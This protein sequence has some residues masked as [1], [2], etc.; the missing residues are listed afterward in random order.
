M[1]LLNGVVG[2]VFSNTPT[3]WNLFWQRI[4]QNMMPL[5]STCERQDGGFFFLE[6]VKYRNTQGLFT[7]NDER[8]TVM[9]TVRFLL[10]NT[11][12]WARLHQAWASMQRWR[13]RH[14]SHWNQWK[15]IVASEWGCNLIA[16]DSIDFNES[17]VASID[18]A[19][20]PTLG[21]NGPKKVVFQ[22]N[23]TKVDLTEG[24]EYE[25]IFFRPTNKFQAQVFLLN[26]KSHRQK[27][28]WSQKGSGNQSDLN[29]I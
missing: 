7:H 5:S 28:H 23:I 15:Q 8:V 9:A 29:G 2:A 24:G 21:V 22:L 27:R 14:N 12:V 18:P 4:I 3:S 25:D 1:R 6:I 26:S 20:T 19:L 17:Y 16:S 10:L 13:L 11:R